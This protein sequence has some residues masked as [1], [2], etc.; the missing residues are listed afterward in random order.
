EIERFGR[1]ML[2]IP[3]HL[4]RIDVDRQGG[5]AEKRVVVDRHSAADR[6]PGF[7]LCRSPEREIEIG[8]I[9]SGDPTFRACAEQVRQLAP[10]VASRLAISRDGVYTPEFF[11]GCS[12]VRANEAFFFAVGGAIAES[13][14]DFTFRH[15]RTAIAP[16]SEEHT[17]E[18][19]SPDHLVCRLLLEKKK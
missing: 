16:Q 15:E 8:I 3:C 11:A 1:S 18:L 19:Q 17:S 12:V 7:R 2:V 6:H 9:A 5:A 4:S 10:R 13:L 14:N